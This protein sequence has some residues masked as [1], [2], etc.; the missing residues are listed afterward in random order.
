MLGERRGDLVGLVRQQAARDEHPRR[1]RRRSP[2][3]RRAAAAGAAGWRASSARSGRAVAQQVERLGAH[4]RAVGARVVERRF[5]ALAL[6]VDA[7]HRI[8]AQPCGS[9]ASTPDPQPRS[10]QRAARL[11]LEQQLQAQPRRVVPA[12]AEGLAGIDHEIL[13]ARR[14]PAPPTAG[15]RAA[16]HA[17]PLTSTGRWNAR[18]RSCQ[19]SG[20]SSVTISTS[21]PP[22][23]ARRSGSVG[24]LAGRPVDRVLD[25]PVDLALLDAGGRELEQLGERQLGVLAPDAQ[26]Q[27]DHRWPPKRRR[28]LSRDAFRSREVRVA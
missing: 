6:V 18:Q 2:C 28:S 20:T 17:A 1:R 21:A 15:A 24:Q 13:A 7:E 23:A 9:D 12:G 5:D 22:A 14:R 10:T 19:S 26:R 25:E 4:V 8:P 16:L 11:E 3:G 27:A